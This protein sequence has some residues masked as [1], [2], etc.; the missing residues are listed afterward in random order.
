MRTV[1]LGPLSTQPPVQP[2]LTGLR[3][4]AHPRRP[5]KLSL[6]C[7]SSLCLPTH[8]PSVVMTSTGHLGIRTPPLSQASLPSGSRCCLQIPPPP[9]VRIQTRPC[10][11]SSLTL[12]TDTLQ[13]PTYPPNLISEEHPGILFEAVTY[14]LL[15]LP[16][17]DLQVKKLRH[18]E[19]KS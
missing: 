13:S 16:C 15:T 6:S 8:I 17:P 9:G 2:S 4:S 14:C 11:A 12:P 1:I 7:S 19:R 3:S 18:R 5:P 10:P